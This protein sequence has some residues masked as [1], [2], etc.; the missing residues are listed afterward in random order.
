MNTIETATIIQSELGRSVIYDDKFK[1][2]IRLTKYAVNRLFQ[3]KSPVISTHQNANHYS[4]SPT[5]A[6][7]QND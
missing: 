5:T 3:T 7:L 2:R 6:H 4:T 1:I